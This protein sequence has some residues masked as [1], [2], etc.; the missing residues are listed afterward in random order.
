MTSALARRGPDAEGIEQ[1]PNVTLGHRRLSIFDL[2]EAGRQPM[3]LPDRSVGVVFN[4]A[5]YNFIPLRRE[6]ESAGYVFHSRTDTEVLLH[7]YLH[8]GI[9][10]LLQ[11]LRGMFAIGLWDQTR[12]KLFLVRDRLGV[13]PLVYSL[14]SGRLAFASTVRALRDGGFAGELDSDALAEFLEFGFVTDDR[15]IYEGI[16]KLRAGELLEWSHGSVTKRLYWDLPSI[17]RSSRIKFEEAV[18]QTESIFLDS[19]K[20]RLE[21]DVPIGALLSGGVDSSL[22]CWAIAKLGGNIRTFTIGT[23]NDPGDESADAVA[24]ARQLGVPHQL[25]ELRPDD[26]PGM[27]DLVNAYGEP[28]ACYSALGMLSVS[29]AVKRHATVLLTGDGGDDIFLGYPEHKHFWMAQRLANSLP[30]GSAASWKLLRQMLPHN[31]ALRRA[32]H[33]IDYATGG[34][35]AIARVHNGLPL[36]RENAL[37]GSRLVD[38]DVSHRQIPLS[39]GSARDLVFEFLKYDRRTRFT[40]EYM[41]KVDGGTMYYALEARSPFLDHEL[42]EY[43]GKLPVEIRLRNGSLKAILRELARRHIGERVSSGAKRGFSIPVQRWLAGRWGSDF[44][45]VISDSVLARDG[46]IHPERVLDLW[47][48]TAPAGTVPLQLWYIYV[49]EHWMRLEQSHR[50]K[51]PELVLQ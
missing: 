35:G 4:G 36:Y 41:T 37:L 28:F 6:L 23:P 18:E 1:W 50:L 49:L 22:V 2:S 29:Q 33:F 48:R 17:D 3:L 9:D 26:S 13:K 7:G 40:G 24:T 47:S 43:A 10:G 38:A 15:T 14:R 20:L 19:V 51:S 34:V 11:R 8:W 31:G 16:A 46:Y 32:K 45:S 27:D 39:P 21:A 30:P 42:W 25:I 12:S 5:I 44:R